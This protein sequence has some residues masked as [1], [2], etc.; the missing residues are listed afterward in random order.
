MVASEQMGHAVGGWR[1][2]ELPVL[3]LKDGR[4]GWGIAA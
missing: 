2:W 4:G 1:D 3:S